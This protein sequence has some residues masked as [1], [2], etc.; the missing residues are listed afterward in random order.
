MNEGPSVVWF[1][2][3]LRLSDH[4]A[5]RAAVDRGRPV[6]CLYVLDTEGEAAWSPGAASRWW[7]HFSLDALGSELAKVGQRLV[8]ARGRSEDVIARLVRDHGVGAVFWNRRYEPSIIARDTVIKARLREQGVEAE[9][10]RG[11]VLFEP[12]SYRTQSGDPYRVF[13]PFWNQI[14]RRDDPPPPL[15]RPRT[16]PP[17]VRGVP[18]LPLAAL[19]LLPSVGWDGGLRESWTPGEDGAHSLLESFGKSGV[20]TYNASRDFPAVQGT[21][22]LSP[23]LHFGEVSPVE[24]WHSIRERQRSLTG[25]DHDN[26]SGYLRQIA[27]REF[28]LHLLFHYPETTTEPLREAFAAFPW[29]TSPADLRSW[30]RGRTGYPIVDA[31]MR[32][33]WHT[34][35]MHNRVRM[36]VGSFLVKH[37]LLHWRLGAEWFWDTLVDA[38]LANNTLG[39][40]WISGCGADAA[41]YFRVFNPILQGA[42]FDSGGTYVKRWVPELAA[43]PVEHIHAPWEAPPEVLRRAEVE[44]GKTYPAPIID[45]KAGRDRALRAYEQVK[46]KAPSLTVSSPKS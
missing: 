27:W 4:P 18:S 34:G 19:E 32:E 23:Y 20:T 10:F 36:V 2:Q 1:R 46:A 25:Q 41:P 38:D 44:L 45:H 37:L 39:W 21:S 14:V 40:Q 26:A 28:A 12:S 43:L 13:T 6:L 42:K 3:D 15:E 33:L 11:S 16:V 22:R 29:R 17:P 30:Q 35:W 7:L 24:A 8:L 5:L 9:S 31:G